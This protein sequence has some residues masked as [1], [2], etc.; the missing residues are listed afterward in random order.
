MSARTFHPSRPGT[1]WTALCH[2][3]ASRWALGVSFPGPDEF[4]RLIQVCE[5][6]A[7]TTCRA[8][9]YQMVSRYDLPKT[10]AEYKGT[11]I[12]LCGSFG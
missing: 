8:V 4:S 5:D 9:F 7:P 10:E 6:T 12:R 3:V 1:G 11:V 2:P